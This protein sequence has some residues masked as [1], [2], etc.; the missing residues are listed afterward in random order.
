MMT[1]PELKE[2][3]KKKD[4]RADILCDLL[5]GVYTERD[6]RKREKDGPPERLEEE[7]KEILDIP[8]DKPKKHK[9]VRSSSGVRF[10]W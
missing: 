3:R 7:I 9:A 4:M 2:A 8:A 1:G 6:V 5:G 10:G